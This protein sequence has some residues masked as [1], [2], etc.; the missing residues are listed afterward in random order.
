[1]GKNQAYPDDE[2]TPRASLHEFEEKFLNCKT[3]DRGINGNIF[4]LLY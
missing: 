4:F 1:M 2:N 3:F